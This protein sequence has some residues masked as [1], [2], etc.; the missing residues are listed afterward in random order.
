MIPLM[1]CFSSIQGEGK[2]TGN[3]SIFVRL[4]GCNFTCAGFGVE[5]QTPD[6]KV[7]HGC[8]SW[9]S[10]DKAFKNT[11]ELLDYKDL[12]NVIN[13]LINKNHQVLPDI[14]FTGGEPTMYWKD[15]DFQKVL[16]YYSS[17]GHHI[18]IETNA[19]I[20]IEITEQYQRDIAFSMSVKLAASGEKQHRRFNVDNI[21]NIISKTKD[22]YLK[23]VVRDQNDIEEIKEL[24]DM[25]PDLADIYLMPLGETKATLENTRMFVVEAAIEN[26]WKYSERIHILIWDDKIGV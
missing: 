15:K 25:L 20:D 21:S 13:K 18:T 16:R 6:G 26:G 2:R 12:I 17:R 24:L 23:F 7:K 4:G 8:D 22:S 11:W 1:E 3:I 5:Y 14:V 19:S 10:V 9:Y